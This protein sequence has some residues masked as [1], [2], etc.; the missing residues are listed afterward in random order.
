MSRS[1][2]APMFDAVAD[3]VSEWIEH[4]STTLAESVVGGHRAPFSA[5]LTEPQK[6]AYYEAQLFAPDGGPNRTGRQALLKRLGLRE[7]VR[8]FQTV[9]A[10]R[11]RR[12]RFLEVEPAADEV[13]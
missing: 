10:D 13:R 2:R 7:Y 9:Q 12:T 5:P 6:R 3:T 4:M 1:P 8:V 11:A